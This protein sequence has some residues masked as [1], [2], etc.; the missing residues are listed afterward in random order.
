[1]SFAARKGLEVLHI[2]DPIDEYATQQFD[3]SGGKKDRVITRMVDP[4]DVYGVQ[5]LRQQL[6]WA[7]AQ[8]VVVGA[9][10]ELRAPE[11]W[12]SYYDIMV[13]NALGNFGGIL[14]EVTY[15]AMQRSCSCRRLFAQWTCWRATLSGPGRR[16]S[17]ALSVTTRISSASSCS[18][19]RSCT[20]WTPSMRMGLVISL[21]VDPI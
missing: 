18:A 10:F 12:L 13:R 8:I 16:C 14:Q 11:L 15:R 2:V 21:M 4:I 7:P 9:G 19:L 5:Q 17:Y 20:W 1:M 6:A 3:D